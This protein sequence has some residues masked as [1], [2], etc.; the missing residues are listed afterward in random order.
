MELCQ[1]TPFI[2]LQRSNNARKTLN[3]WSPLYTPRFPTN[4][5]DPRPH[6]VGPVFFHANHT[7]FPQS[8]VLAHTQINQRAIPSVGLS[9]DH[10]RRP[11]HILPLLS[12]TLAP[13]TPERSPPR[14]HNPLN[15]PRNPMPKTAARGQR[16]T[17][18]TWNVR[19]LLSEEVQRKLDQELTR[20]RVPIC[21]LQETRLPT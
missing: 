17:L 3:V 1:T 5:R 12:P 6:N 9:S 14:S 8:R 19:T 2:T 13:S 18:G 7:I 20:L 10:I 15:P 21:A 11:L 16:F 4:L